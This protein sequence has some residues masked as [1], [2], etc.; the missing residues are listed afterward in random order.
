S[1]LTF[2][3]EWFCGRCDGSAD[4]PPSSA[5]FGWPAPVPGSWDAVRARFATGLERATALGNG[6]TARPISPPIEHPPLAGYTV[7]DAIEHMAA[8]NSHHLGQVVLLRQMLGAWPPPSGS[9]T[10]ASSRP[11]RAAAPDAGRVAAAIGQ[12]HVV[13]GTKP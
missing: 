5:A 10:C 13:V 2:W 8:H 9:D 12:L 11:G 3:Q 1:H 4:P 7:R 6:D